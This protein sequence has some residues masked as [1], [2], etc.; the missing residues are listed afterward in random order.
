MGD[1]SR[2]IRVVAPISKFLR[3]IPVVSFY[4]LMELEAELISVDFNIEAYGNLKMEKQ[5]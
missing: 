3:L 5:F 2:L 4:K 1:L